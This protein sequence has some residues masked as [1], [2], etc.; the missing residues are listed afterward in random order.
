MSGMVTWTRQDLGKIHLVSA[1]S[2]DGSRC[3]ETS[4]G[5]AVVQAAG[6]NRVPWQQKGKETRDVTDQGLQTGG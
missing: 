6:G 1:G 4:E 5:L 2:L 3:G